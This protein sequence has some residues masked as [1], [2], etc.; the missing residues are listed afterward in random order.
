[1][2][3][4]V[5][6]KVSI[7]FID[8]PYIM[9]LSYIVE[10]ILPRGRQ[11]AASFDS[12]PH[13]KP[14]CNP[15][16]EVWQRQRNETAIAYKAFGVYRDM[17]AERSLSKV[18]EKLGRKSGYERQLQEW[19]SQHSWVERAAAYDR[20]LEER[21]TAEFEESLIAR[22]RK[23][24]ELEVKH[25]DALLSKFDEALDLV[26]AHGFQRKT[27]KR[28]DAEGKE[29]EIVLVEINVDDLRTMT[30]WRRDL[31]SLSR[32]T[33]GLPEKITQGQHTGKDGGAIVIED[34]WKAEFI[35][36][37]REG[38]ITPAELEAEIGSDLAREV[39]NAS[40]LQFFDGGEGEET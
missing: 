4:V 15:M 37:L 32:L 7:W 35:A 5:G 29:I 30:Q 20:Q 22:R 3:L 40:G 17:G 21:L 8:T 31:A 12:T 27:S 36:L 24:L 23:L 2:Q 9:G 13:P 28:K 19:S 38:K 14:K 26:K 6:G 33:V 39:V 16:S 34:K 25:V 11:R 10:V 18:R 1:V